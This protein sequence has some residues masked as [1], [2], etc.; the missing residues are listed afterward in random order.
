MLSRDNDEWG[1]QLGWLG[2]GAQLG[3]RRRQ[4]MELSG[5]GTADDEAVDRKSE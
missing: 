3:W 5:V 2:R 1:A 4:T